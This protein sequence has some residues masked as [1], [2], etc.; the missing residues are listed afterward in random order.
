MPLITSTS[1][2]ITAVPKRV[3]YLDFNL[4]LGEGAIAVGIIALQP[5]ELDCSNPMEGLIEARGHICGDFS[6][7]HC[8]FA[9]IALR[10]Q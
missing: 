9:R 1:E 5:I 3:F 10:D 2:G 7:F 4:P 8:L 6:G